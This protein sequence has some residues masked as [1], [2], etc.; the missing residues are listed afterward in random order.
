MD[1]ACFNILIV[2]RRHTHTLALALPKLKLDKPMPMLSSSFPNTIFH[3][4]K[5]K[6]SKRKNA[7]KK[8]ILK[9]TTTRRMMM[10]HQ[11]LHVPVSSGTSYVD[12]VTHPVVGIINIIICVM[13]YFV[14]FA[15]HQGYIMNTYERVKR[16]GYSSY[17]FFSL[18]VFTYT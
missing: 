14:R 13:T 6:Q 8:L 3:E 4:E 16:K 7:T 2:A 1:G 18:F 15:V 5:T 12:I 10:E 11:H 17:P 9:K